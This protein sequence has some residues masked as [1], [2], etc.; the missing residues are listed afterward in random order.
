MV[1]VFPWLRNG[2]GFPA[3]P[4]NDQN[5]LRFAYRTLQSFSLVYSAAFFFFLTSEAR[6]SL[7]T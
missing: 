4:Q 1:S 6:F 3:L 7:S 2:Q 5:K